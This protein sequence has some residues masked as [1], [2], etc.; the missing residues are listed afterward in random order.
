MVHCVW[1]ENDEA[2][3]IRLHC[4]NDLEDINERSNSNSRRKAH[5]DGWACR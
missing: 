5:A 3:R 1:Q 4:L 2:D